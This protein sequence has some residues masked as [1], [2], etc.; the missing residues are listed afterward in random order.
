MS[1]NIYRVNKKSDL[2]EIMKNNMYKPICICFLSKSHN[3]N[4]WNDLL[5][6]L[7]TISKIN[8]YLMNIIIDFDNFTDDFNGQTGYFD[9]IK[10]NTP[11]FM[12]FF[13]G[14]V[15][16]STDNSNNF[17]PIVINHIEQIHKSYLN[18]LI[19]VFENQNQNQEQPHMTN[20]NDSNLDNKNNTQNKN[21]GKNTHE[22]NNERDNERNNE[23][24]NER[25]N[26]SNNESNDA[27]NNESDNESNKESDN[28]NKKVSTK[29]IKRKKNKKR[30]TK[31]N[32]DEN[33]NMSTNS[34]DTMEIEKK[35]ERLKKLKKLKELQN[36]LNQ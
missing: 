28:H 9:S 17:I 2:D 14:K 11:Y 15:I 20:P 8:T 19:D 6:T 29:I 32:I 30:K 31:E 1:K 23:S 36:L 22:R 12:A 10:N 16:V 27:S 21:S 3:N 7:L 5:S 18:K 24:N 34:N 25:D 4:M 13:K 33:N 26:E 35:K